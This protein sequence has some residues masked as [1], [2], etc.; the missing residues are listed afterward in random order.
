MELYENTYYT[1]EMEETG[2]KLLACVPANQILKNSYASDLDM[3]Q[4]EAVIRNRVRQDG[5]TENDTGNLSSWGICSLGIPEWDARERD[6]AAETAS[7]LL[8][9]GRLSLELRKRDGK[10]EYRI[11]VPAEGGNTLPEAL[12]GL[13]GQAGLEGK[14]E[15][16]Q[17]L[18][19]CGEAV[20]DRY[21]DKEY[22]RRPPENAEVFN[23]PSA[24]ISSMVQG[25]YSVVMQ[26]CPM[27][28]GQLARMQKAAS[29]A[30]E[31]CSA[32]STLSTQAGANASI[33]L[34]GKEWIGKSM[35]EIVVGADKVSQ[36]D[37]ISTSVSFSQKR[38][39]AELL[40]ER[41]KEYAERIQ[42]GLRCG[43]WLISLRVLASQQGALKALQAVIKA[44]F[45]RTPFS[46]AWDEGA[47]AG[48]EA[49]WITEKE[50]VY[51]A[52]LPRDDFPGFRRLKNREFALCSPYDAVD[53][54]SV[55]RILWNAAE[56]DMEF[57]IPVQMFNRHAFICGMTGA[58]KT[59]TMFHLLRRLDRPF[60]VIEP[61]KSEYYQL[62]NTFPD[63]QV[64]S[65]SV[66]SS[67][68]LQIN[69]FWFPAGGN[70]QYH[71]DSL[72]AIISSAFVLYA[73]MP[74]ILEQCLYRIYRRCG[75]NISSSRNVY[76]GLLP[77]AFLYPTFST[78][79]E[80][81]ERYLGESDYE[82]ESLSTYK[83]ALLT[84]LQSFSS[85]TKGILFNHNAHPEY[86][87]WYG[88]HII[89]ELEELADDADKCI[90]MG[91]V[92]SQY[93]QYLKLQF[94]HHRD[95][96]LKHLIVI[97]EAHRLF[98][99]AAGT[100]NPESASSVEQLVETLG[101]M[102]AEIRAYGEGMLIVDQ[103]PA[104]IAEDVLRNSSVKLIH[105]L[106]NRNDIQ[107]VDTVLKMED[108]EEFISGLGQGEAFVCTERM[109]KAA[110]IHIARQKGRAEEN[111][112]PRGTAK[113]NQRLIDSSMADYL[114]TDG[115]FHRAMS[116][117]LDKFIN[118]VLYDSLYVNLNAALEKMLFET[119]RLVFSYG[120]GLED[121]ISSRD[122]MFYLLEKEITKQIRQRF[123]LN[124]LIAGYCIMMLMRSI[125]LYCGRP[126]CHE[127]TA[128][129]SG[130]R[131]IQIYDRLVE[132][133]QYSEEK[134]HQL[135]R[136][137][138]GKPSPNW[139]LLIW[140]GDAI[141]SI[142]PGFQYKGTQE[143]RTFLQ[144]VLRMAFIVPPSGDA[145]E[146]MLRK[147]KKIM[148]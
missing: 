25:D 23:W 57:E 64:F 18:K 27:A 83:G 45:S 94:V 52:Q 110:R 89:L 100:K 43:A 68:V 112:I 41:L 75:W 115:A 48:K 35:E 59:N 55:G 50:A 78:L 118:S 111:C 88:R 136:M 107:M 104:K 132:I 95:E 21:F 12:R 123:P 42:E 142:C 20:F 114:L 97:E 69:P 81:I 80:E 32:A 133:Y 127:E 13:Y 49:V 4:L 67:N 82:G 134:I 103:S 87:E 128:L 62:K 60:L 36:G 108:S 85:G 101:N 139:E 79:C 71:I 86:S 106:D 113:D 74:E 147:I 29:E 135:L 10:A 44:S 61:V 72:K 126:L 63:I 116:Q 34:S 37:G 14:T 51:F 8:G 16:I 26:I 11:A 33:S 77:E 102:M 39:Q 24:V 9:Q 2:R 6:I 105:R 38:L 7:L 58:G 141:E 92:M 19:Y 131:E 40:M 148:G 91:V 56:S 99:N 17:H 125:E 3:A 70:L 65:M 144:N 1:K 96:T 137:R 90:V 145:A 53:S 98:K 84:R 117:M 76:E 130:F 121:Y 46:L 146:N 120:N 28:E 5:D 138:I 54:I 31:Q 109:D 129:L 73:A 93:Y 122:F 15:E 143:D 119:R 30:Y 22:K 47:G 66:A 124:N 140:F